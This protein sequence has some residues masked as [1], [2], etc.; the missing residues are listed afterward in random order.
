VR[1]ID[2]SWFQYPVDTA[3]MAPA[4]DAFIVR[5]CDWVR[6]AN[7]GQDEDTGHNDVIRG[8]QAQG[9]LASSYL[10]ARPEMCGATQQ[11]DT[12][13]S[14]VSA[15]M[16]MPPL[17]DIE[18]SGIT[19]NQLMDWTEEA[20][21][22]MRAIWGWVPLHYFSGSLAAKLGT[23]RPVSPHL[24]MVP[25]YPYAN[26]D[27]S[28]Y[29]W[30]QRSQWVAQ[31]D[32]EARVA[33][34]LPPGYSVSDV[35]L[36]QFAD[37][38][39]APGTNNTVDVS[40]VYPAFAG[41]VGGDQV[42]AIG[43][44]GTDI[45]DLARTQ[46]G[47]KESPPDS[48]QVIYWDWWGRN[49]GAWC[50]VFVSYI[51]HEAGVPLPAI[52]G[53]LG[54]I[55]CP[56]GQVFAYRNGQATF[57]PEAGDIVIFSWQP[58]K[59]EDGISVCS[60]G[61]YA[62]QAAGDHTGIFVRWNGAPGAGFTSIEGNTS[63]TNWDDGGAVLERSDR[64]ASQVCCWWRPPALSAGLR[65]ASVQE[66]D[67]DMMI[68]I[69]SDPAQG[70]DGSLYVCLG[71]YCWALNAD[72]DRI[73]LEQTGTLKPGA[74]AVHPATIDIYDYQGVLEMDS[75]NLRTGP[76]PAEVSLVAGQYDPLQS[77]IN[78]SYANLS[79]SLD[80]AQKKLDA[81]GKMIAALPGQQTPTPVPVLDIEA[82]LEKASA[83][84]LV[85]ALTRKLT[86]Q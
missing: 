79:A 43:T 59:M 72:A 71:P 86:A 6:W 32:G 46:I 75:G 29:G 82:S 53:P 54:F 51:F 45:V 40:H 56:S 57:A 67:D 78:G 5:W 60:T 34:Y 19:G 63:Q 30:D 23:R 25:G 73:A 62:G 74:K 15:P 8:F 61:E 17:L 70:G 31:A 39:A 9:K 58:T 14:R 16:T 28:R 33:D 68:Q 20:L 85:T 52:N 27:R 21:T 50:A 44:T 81:A 48:N 69:L 80:L 2:L 36:W 13:A 83:Q 65:P 84:Q 38:A 64:D 55:S 18:Q 26:Q 42:S 49:Y 77:G 1:V 4:A 41:T 76:T 37:S 10:F 22:R 24:L 11:I 12:W 35:G 7:Y 66:E 3:A 47:V